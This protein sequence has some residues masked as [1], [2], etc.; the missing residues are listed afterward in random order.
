ME[1]VCTT[2]FAALEAVTSV[3]TI[4]TFADFAKKCYFTRCQMMIKYYI[5]PNFHKF[6]FFKNFE[7]SKIEWS[8]FTLQIIE[9]VNLICNLLCKSDVQI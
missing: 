7:N 1:T 3:R 8:N 6:Q 5:A 2:T 4:C 9:N